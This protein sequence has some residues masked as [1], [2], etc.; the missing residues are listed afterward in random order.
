MKL[1][2]R[3]QFLHL[4]AGALALPALSRFTWSQTYPAR[5]VRIVV[6]FAAG[7]TQDVIARF[8]Q[9]IGNVR[10]KDREAATPEA[11]A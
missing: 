2:Y 6:G 5:P 8:R 9:R 4:A 11:A 3:R 10:N 1:P 7:G